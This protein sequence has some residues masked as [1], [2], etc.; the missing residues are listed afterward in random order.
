VAEKQNKKFWNF[1]FVF[2]YLFCLGGALEFACES[3]QQVELFAMSAPGVPPRHDRRGV[4][5]M[6]TPSQGVYL[7][8][9]F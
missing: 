1:L 4:S 7:N 8:T 5:M 9:S 3:C 2:T 6:M